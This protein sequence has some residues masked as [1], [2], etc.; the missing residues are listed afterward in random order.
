M[1]RLAAATSP[2]P[3]RLSV[4]SVP[5]SAPTVAL[6][7][8]SIQH[9]PSS[10]STARSGSLPVD[11]F[12]KILSVPSAG[13]LFES[14]D[15]VRT[16]GFLGETSSTAVVAELNSTLGI[17]APALPNEPRSNCVSEALVRRGVQVLLFFQDEGRIRQ[18]FD[19]CFSVGDGEGFLIFRPVYLAWLNGFLPVLNKAIKTN[20]LEALSAKVWHNTQNPVVLTSSTTAL[21]WAQSTTGENIRWETLGLLISLTGLMTIAL[22]SW[23]HSFDINPEDG[24][25]K[26]RDTL[27]NLVNICL[28]FSKLSGSRDVLLA[29]LSYDAFLVVAVLQGDTS[30]EAWT[31]FSDVC[32]MVTL[33]GIH[34]ENR[35]DAE[36]PFFLCELRSRLFMVCFTM[37]KFI[38]T[39]L[40]RP[41]KISWRYSVIVRLSFPFAYNSEL[42]NVLARTA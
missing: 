16:V 24:K 31:R 42:M 18:T 32:D 12:P 38:A 14:S 39:F 27:P 17:R 41:P 19:Q 5:N 9:T 22:P 40:G 21:A 11:R 10:T 8:S 28:D 36:T 4:A 33:Q 13:I 35:T 29:V 2:S 20:S 25:S 30:T 6:S 23:H 15:R 3:A 7:G 37:D 26:L 1:T 34:L